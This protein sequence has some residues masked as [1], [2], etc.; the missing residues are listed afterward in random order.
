MLERQV[1]DLSKNLELSM[2]QDK[3]DVKLLEKY[4][5]IDFAQDSVSAAYFVSRKRS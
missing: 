2:A 3:I 5:H 4:R 1:A